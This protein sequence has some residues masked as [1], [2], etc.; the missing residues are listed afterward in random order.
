M[1]KFL[2][3]LI[4]VPFVTGSMVQAQNNERIAAEKVAFFTR[5]LGLSVDEAEKFWPVYNDYSSRREKM[6]QDKNSLMKYVNQNF[7]NLSSKELEESADRIIQYSVD[8]ASLLKEYHEKFKSIL[9]PEKVIR[10]YA[11]EIQFKT[12]LLNQLQERRQQQPAG[13]NLNR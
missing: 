2:L 6:N 13:R 8:E 10:L 5:R 11:T 12:Y 7:R 9:S 4:I 1:K 3:L